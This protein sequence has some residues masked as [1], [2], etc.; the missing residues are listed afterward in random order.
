MP[1]MDGHEATRRIKGSPGGSE[2]PIIAVTASALEEERHV[3]LASGA[4][5]FVRKPFKE[6][7][8]LDAIRRV[9]G[10]EYTYERETPP[11]PEP[12]SGVGEVTQDASAALPP[13]LVDRLRDAAIKLATSRLK[14]LFEE[15]AIHDASLATE[16]EDLADRFE[17]RAILKLL[18][19]EH[20]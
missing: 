13:D 17:Y 15:V 11:G 12:T 4:D 18:G 2:T 8:L 19:G 20:D 3:A 10:A 9:L 6:T 1:V 7:D 5:D 14:I 16:L